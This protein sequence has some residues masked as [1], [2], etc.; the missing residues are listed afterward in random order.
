MHAKRYVA[1]FAVIAL[2][3]GVGACIEEDQ[4]PAVSENAPSARPKVVEPQQEGE[5]LVTYGDKKL[6]SRQ[7]EFLQA[8][9]DDK[10]VRQIADWWIDLQL[11]DEEAR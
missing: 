6:T 7:I 1:V 5:V 9:A 3:I 2:L 10:L 8:G 4:K 11:L